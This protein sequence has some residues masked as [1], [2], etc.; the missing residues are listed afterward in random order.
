[1]GTAGSRMVQ[2]KVDFQKQSADSLRPKLPFLT[3]GKFLK[4]WA[5]LENAAFPC[6]F[7]SHALAIPLTH[8]PL[9]VF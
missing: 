4:S 1:M 5:C 8:V 7:L 9:S 2:R 6:F 3:K